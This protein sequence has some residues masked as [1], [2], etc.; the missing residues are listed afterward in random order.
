MEIGSSIDLEEEFE[1]PNFLRYLKATDIAIC[2]A[3]S[4]GLFAVENEATTPDEGFYHRNEYDSVD[5]WAED[6]APFCEDREA[7]AALV[8]KMRNLASGKEHRVSEYWKEHKI[9]LRKC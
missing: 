8:A 3:L 9:L 6:H 1:E 5:E 4:E 2:D 7:F